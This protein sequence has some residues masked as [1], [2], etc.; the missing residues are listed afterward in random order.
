M[1]SREKNKT[2][3][4]ASPITVAASETPESPS[5]T[6]RQTM[7]RQCCTHDHDTMLTLFGRRMM[8]RAC[9]FDP[10]LHLCLMRRADTWTQSCHLDGVDAYSSEGVN[11]DL[12]FLLTALRPQLEAC[13]LVQIH[14]LWLQ[15]QLPDSLRCGVGDCLI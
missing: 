10:H 2:P 3:G 14:R 12:W 7:F 15:P 13:R 6:S 11:G 1:I 9:K 5:S 8:R 4:H